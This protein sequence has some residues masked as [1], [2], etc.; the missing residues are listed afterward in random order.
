MGTGSVRPTENVA[1]QIVG[2][3]GRKGL[4]RTYVA[5]DALNGVTRAFYLEY[6]FLELLDDT[7]HLFLPNRKL[8]L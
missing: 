7:P 3:D 1:F 5:V 2:Q 4:E 6:G 8:G